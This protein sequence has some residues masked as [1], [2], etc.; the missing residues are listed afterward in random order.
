MERCY[1]RNGVSNFAT[2]EI[3]IYNVIYILC[4]TIH[5]KRINAI[6]IQYFITC[7]MYTILINEFLNFKF[8]GCTAKLSEM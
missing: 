4:S 2:L 8:C 6:V 3:R 1:F 5:Y 7:I